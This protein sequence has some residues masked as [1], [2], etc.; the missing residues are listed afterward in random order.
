MV[1]YTLVIFGLASVLFFAHALKKEAAIILRD[2]PDIIVQKLTAGRQDLIP[3]SYAEGIRQ[4]RGGDGSK[5]ASL[6]LLL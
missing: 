5:G 3:M 4:I 6:G 2:T 1:V